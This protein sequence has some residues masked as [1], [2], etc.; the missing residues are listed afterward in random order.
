MM[1]HSIPFP[2]LWSVKP[3]PKTGTPRPRGPR[4]YPTTIEEHPRRRPWDTNCRMLLWMYMY[5]SREREM[6]IYSMFIYIYIHMIYYRYFWSTPYTLAFDIFHPPQAL[7]SQRMDR[8]DWDLLASRLNS[9]RC[10]YITWMFIPVS[11][12]VNTFVAIYI[13]C[14]GGYAYIYI[15]IQCIYIS[16]Y[17]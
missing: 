12:Q 11:K 8:L 6:H 17:I 3:S 14:V 2:I 4:A 9:K 7:R 16:I 15:Y 10:D 5:W 13:V 1:S